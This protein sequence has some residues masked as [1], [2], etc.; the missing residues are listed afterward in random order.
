MYSNEP[1]TYTDLEITP[2]EIKFYLSSGF[3]LHTISRIN[4]TM[5]VDLSDSGL[6]K[7]G[8]LKGKCTKGAA[9]F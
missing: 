2:S 6:A 5:I 8:N 3:G 1:E 7:L 4:G 9:Q